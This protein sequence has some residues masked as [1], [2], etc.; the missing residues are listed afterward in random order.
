MLHDRDD[1]VGSLVPEHIVIISFADICIQ[2]TKI[3][4]KMEWEQTLRN[5][6]VH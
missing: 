3:S 5:T 2:E 4:I 6:M 1:A